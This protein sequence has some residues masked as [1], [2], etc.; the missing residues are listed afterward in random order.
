M[1]ACFYVYI[2]ASKSR[3][4][5]I[6]ITNTCGDVSGS[7]RTASA[8]DSRA[9]TGFIGWCTSSAFSMFEMPFTVRSSLKGGCE[10]ERS[11]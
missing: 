5:Y 1:N 6:G 10:R 8:R 9:T 7:T 11:H 4:L 3:V 2:M